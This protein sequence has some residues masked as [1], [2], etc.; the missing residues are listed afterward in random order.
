MV[1]VKRFG[2][3][4]KLTLSILRNTKAM[5]GIKKQLFIDFLKNYLI[6]SK[7]QMQITEI[8]LDKMNDYYPG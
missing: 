4:E 1:K 8:L 6:S 7:I 3:N 2:D 5:V